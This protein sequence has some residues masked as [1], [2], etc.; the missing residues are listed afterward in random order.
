[1]ADII[2]VPDWFNQRGTQTKLKY[3]GVMKDIVVLQG[4]AMEIVVIRQQPCGWSI[5][6]RVKNK[7]SVGYVGGEVFLS[8]E[9]MKAAWGVREPREQI[10]GNKGVFGKDG[11]YARQ[12]KFL[13]FPAMG[14]GKDGNPNASVYLTDDIIK[15][16]TDIFT[17]KELW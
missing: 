9:D 5:R 8:E 14:G 2:N 10:N 16:F 4:E 15:L 11:V 12:D 1:M 13:S 6:W 3:T 17:P 7:I